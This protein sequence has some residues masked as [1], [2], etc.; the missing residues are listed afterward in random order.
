MSIRSDAWSI[1]IG[2]KKLYAKRFSTSGAETTQR[3]VNAE[4]SRIMAE[5]D[6]LYGRN[7]FNVAGIGALTGLDPVHADW[8]MKFWDVRTF[9]QTDFT[10]AFMQTHGLPEWYKK[11]LLQILEIA[12]KYITPDIF[13]ELISAIYGVLYDLYQL[14]EKIKK[15]LMKAFDILAKAIGLVFNIVIGLGEILKKLLELLLSLF[16]QKAKD[17]SNPNEPESNVGENIN[18]S[19]LTKAKYGSAV[20]GKSY[21]DPY[22][23]IKLLINDTN[24]MFMRY[25]LDTFLRQ[26]DAFTD[27]MNPALVFASY[28]VASR[29]A[30]VA[31]RMLFWDY[32]HWDKDYWV[33]NLVPQ[34]VARIG[35]AMASVNT[36][37]HDAPLA[38]SDQPGPY[39]VIPVAPWQ[40]EYIEAPVS[41]IPYDSAIAG[42]TVATQMDDLFDVM[43]TMKW[44][45]SYWDAAF[46][47]LAD[48]TE[49]FLWGI[50]PFYQVP[51]AQLYMDTY[52]NNARYLQIMYD[53]IA[54]TTSEPAAPDIPYANYS[55]KLWAYSQTQL[56]W[57]RRKAEEWLNQHGIT[58]PTLVNMYISAL[59]NYYGLHTSSSRLKTWF[60]ALSGIMD[61]K[62]KFIRR[63]EALGLDPDILKGLIDYMGNFIAKNAELKARERM[64]IQSYKKTIRSTIW[65]FSNL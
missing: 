46:W 14:F 55:I 63:W 9:T 37:D 6:S 64:K 62:Q 1:L 58:S 54:I 60:F 65:G 23:I 13:N 5:T 20:V 44:D 32:G 17:E 4:L 36:Y 42:G 33:G 21:Y 52:S 7:I 29:N 38:F 26:V 51:Y 45:A 28:D 30:V 47:G 8:A 56:R 15:Y 48:Q 2:E 12:K 24:V 25:S 50:E 39:Y 19:K 22:D 27:I 61:D 43:M 40:P 49:Q 3:I 10:T 34:T 35:F 11:I 16:G 53:T 57:I 59:W 31:D 41:Y 18:E